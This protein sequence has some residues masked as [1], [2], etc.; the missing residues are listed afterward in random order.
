[1]TSGIS[2]IRATDPSVHDYDA[3]IDIIAASIEVKVNGAVGNCRLCLPE[4][5]TNPATVRLLASEQSNA[6]RDPKDD[7]YLILQGSERFE[8]YLLLWLNS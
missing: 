4:G 8:F 3:L 2:T 1:V 5:Y 6:N 7:I